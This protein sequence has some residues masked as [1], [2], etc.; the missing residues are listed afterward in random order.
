MRLRSVHKRRNSQLGFSMIELMLSMLILSIIMGAVF[1]EVAKVQRRYRMEEQR[2]DVFQTSRE[3]LDQ[4]IRDI[5]QAGFPNPKMY[6]PGSLGASPQTSQLNAV[7]IFFASD[8]SIRF[9]ADV[10]SDGW[11]DSMSYTLQPNSGGPGDQNCPCLR[12]SQVRK[13]P[14]IDPTAQAL[15]YQTQVESVQGTIGIFQFYTKEGNEVTFPGGATRTIWDPLSNAEP[16]NNVYTVRINLNVRAQ[17]GDI[18]TGDRP[19]VFLSSSA[20]VNN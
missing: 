14:G 7:G 4:M 10:D 12:R 5:H 18:M 1:N 19:Q 20:Q 6:A 9:E 15:N 8:T 3:F 2:L 17:G 16:L 11:V 13:A